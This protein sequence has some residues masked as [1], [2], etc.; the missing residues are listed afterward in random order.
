M[1]FDIDFPKFT[2]NLEEH[3]NWLKQELY[4][5]L[6]IYKWFCMITL[7]TGGKGIHIYTYNK[8]PSELSD[9]DKISYFNSCYQYKSFFI[10][11]ALYKIYKN[12][13]TDVSLDFIFSLLDF[14]M[15]KPEQTINVTVYD[16]EPLINN[17]FELE[18]CSPVVDNIKKVIIHGFIR[19]A[20][21]YFHCAIQDLNYSMNNMCL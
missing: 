5:K 15:Y 20:I 13:N 19:K 17:N 8:I 12:T 21:H 3:I 1:G 2:Q 11:L 10:Y 6:K 14:A 7:S 16:N 4:N 18:V 9:N